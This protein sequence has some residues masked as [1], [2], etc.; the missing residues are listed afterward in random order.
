MPN[1]TLPADILLLAK[2]VDAASSSL[3]IT[4][5]QLPDH[6]IIFCNA[7][8]EKLTGYAPQEVLGRNCRFLQ[9]N[10]TG[11]KYIQQ[12]RECIAAGS[13]CTVAIRN[14]R[15]DGTVFWNELVLSPVKTEDGQVTHYIGIQKDITQ[16]MAGRDARLDRVN[17]LSHEIK[18]PLTTIKSTL[19]VLHQ[20]GVQVDEPFLKKSL[21]AALRAVNRLEELSRHLFG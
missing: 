10:D 11:Q 20:R 8:F 15:K 13:H 17:L 2:A 21:A 1:E 7:A 12:I 16:Q 18:T 3:I 6:P 9:G 14:Y 5:Q 4:D 19:Q